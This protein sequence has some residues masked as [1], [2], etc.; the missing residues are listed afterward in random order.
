MDRRDFLKCSSKACV[1]LSLG[2]F[3]N[4]MLLQSCTSSLQILKVEQ[5]QGWVAV[6][7]SKFETGNY[8]M[9]RVKEFPFD[10]GIQK[11]E[12]KNYVA[13]VLMCP[14]AN[15]PLTKAG[16]G[17]ICTLHGSRFAQN[18]DLLKGPSTLPLYELPIVEEN[19]ELKIQTGKFKV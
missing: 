18:G 12:N 2:V 4:S 17:Y 10:I 3:F 6:P 1:G 19:G 9:L 13:L 5:S 11:I 16:N 8:I 7:L 14:H 15:Q